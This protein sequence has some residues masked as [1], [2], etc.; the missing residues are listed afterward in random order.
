MSCFSSVR[1]AAFI[2]CLFIIVCLSTTV[3]LAACDTK[4]AYTGN[5]PPVITQLTAEHTLLYPLGNTK[6]ECVAY[7]PDGDLLSYKWMTNNGSIAGNGASIIWEAPRYY[8]DY[9][10]MV[11]VDDAYGHSVSKVVTVTVIVRE[12]DKNC[13]SCPK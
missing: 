11:S 10:I 7:D 8:G 9:H 3:F 1:Q 13:S 12:P 6:I 4:P 5:Q 2:N